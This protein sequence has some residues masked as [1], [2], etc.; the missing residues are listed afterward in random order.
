M[1]AC[2][3]I[4]SKPAVSGQNADDTSFIGGRPRIPAGVDLPQCRLCGADLTFFYQVAFPAGHVWQSLSMAVFACTSCAHEQ[5]L[6]P[7][8]LTGVLAGADIP[9]GFLTQYQRNFRIVVFE[10]RSGEQRMDYTPKIRF[11]RLELVPSRKTA[12]KRNKLG[13]KPNWLLDDESPATYAS[14]VPMKFLMQWIEPPRFDLEDDAPAQ[15]RL[16]LRGKPEPSR[17]RYYEL[18]LGNQLYF[19]GT[20]AGHEPLVYVITQI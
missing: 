4:E 5:Y 10:T 18:F 13:G 19:F 7:E 9:Q 20:E 17:H 1:D 11:N 8:M 2:W 6:I 14:S 3:F 15:I 16:G 12:A